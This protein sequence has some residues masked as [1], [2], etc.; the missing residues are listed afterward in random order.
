MVQ[1]TECLLAKMD[2]NQVALGAKTDTNKTGSR[3]V[4]HAT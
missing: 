2:A 4:G 3:N 1:M